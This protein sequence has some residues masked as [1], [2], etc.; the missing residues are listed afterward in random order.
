MSD[1]AEALRL[2]PTL[3]EAHLIRTELFARKGQP[4]QARAARSEALTAFY[5]RGVASIIK[6]DY[7]PAIADLE[8][9]I[10]EAPDRAEAHA[11]CGKA[12]YLRLDFPS[13]VQGILQ[14]NRP[15]ARRKAKLQ[16]PGHGSFSNRV[17]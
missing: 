2:D 13:A 8:R 5:R 6:H 16:R 3:A 9:V 14:G 10:R 12:Y 15:R 17:V 11:W 4:D 1:A 7:E